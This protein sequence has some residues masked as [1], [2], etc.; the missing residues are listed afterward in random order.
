M[1]IFLVTFL[2]C[3]QV[4][5]IMNRLQNI[6]LLTLEQKAEIAQEIKKVVPSCPIIIKNK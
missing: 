6:A 5:I 3:G 1:S 4:Q 2:S